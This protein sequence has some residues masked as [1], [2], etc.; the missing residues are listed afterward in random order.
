M[1]IRI[2][3]ALNNEG[4]FE[5]KHF[6]DADKYHIYHF[7]NGA[8][9]LLYE[10]VNQ[11]KSVDETTVHGSKKKA[12]QIIKFLEDKNV[13]VLVSRR[14]GKNIQF[15]VNHF[16]PVEVKE[17]APEKVKIIL[18]KHIRWL[19]DEL[20][21]HPKEHNKFVMDSGILKTAVRNRRP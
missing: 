9:N 17:E 19:Q 8:L 2:A 1:E 13:S 4:E 20:N 11:F 6:G 5:K 14:F 7:N 21:N 18:L 16:I 12:D 10:E 15:I 3:F